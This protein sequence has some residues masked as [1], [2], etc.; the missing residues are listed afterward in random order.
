MIKHHH[1]SSPI[2]RG[3]YSL[4]ILFV[5][6]M[7]GTIGMHQLEDLPYIDAFYFTSMIATAQGPTEK[8]VTAAGKIFASVLAF[9][10]AG[11]GVACLGFVFGPL[12]GQL[13]HIGR[14]RVEEDL[15]ERKK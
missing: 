5:I 1:L 6:T 14:L 13:W 12:L 9:V 10:S 7:V 4:I 15:R 8:P 11:A 2:R 3:L